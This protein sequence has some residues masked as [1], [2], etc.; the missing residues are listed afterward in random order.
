MLSPVC[1]P[2]GSTF[3]IEQTAIQVS[4]ASRITSYSISCQ[5]T[6]QRS[7]I[8]WRIG[9]ARKPLCTRSQY[10]SSVATMPPPVP[11]RVK[12][13]RMMAGR[14][15]CA[16]ASFAAC[17]RSSSLAPC[18]MAL[19]A[20]GWPMR[21]HISRKSSRSSAI[22]IAESGVPRRRIGCRLK[23]PASSSATAMLSAV[24]PPSPASSPSGFSRSMMRSITS[25]VSGSK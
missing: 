8:T 12:A 14:P 1:T 24:C 18:T 3:S 20:V 5:P 16:S 25:T 6:R 9:L 15:I 13:G 10:S 17:M 11:P 19:G 2:S 22:L 21:S 4:S 23:T 7:I